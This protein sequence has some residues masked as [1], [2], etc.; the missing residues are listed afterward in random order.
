MLVTLW[1]KLKSDATSNRIWSPKSDALLSVWV[2]NKRLPFW[3][4][5]TSSSIPSPVIASIFFVARNSSPLG[6]A[7]LTPADTLIVILC[8]KNTLL[9]ESTFANSDII[10]SPSVSSRSLLVILLSSPSKKEIPSW[11]SSSNTIESPASVRISDP[12]SSWDVERWPSSVPSK[13]K[14][15]D[16]TSALS[17]T[18]RSKPSVINIPNSPAPVP[19]EIIIASKSEYAFS[20]VSIWRIPTPV[21]SWRVKLF[22]SG[23]EIESSSIMS[24]PSARTPRRRCTGSLN[25]ERNVVER[26][27]S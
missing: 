27:A 17:E 19:W 5:P 7:T 9:S 13:T 24:S 25:I 18:I 11:I 6:V 3:S 8:C 23:W 12:A 4:V 1:F 14:L 26:I 2:S 16:I 21:S 15:F 22:P 10:L 20:G